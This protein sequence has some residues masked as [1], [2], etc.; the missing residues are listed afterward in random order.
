[1]TPLF[2]LLDLL[3][4]RALA[5]A[6]PAV[7]QSSLLVL[8]LLLTER[9]LRHKLRPAVR[10]ALWL[11]V[12]IKLLLPPS[13][14]LPT[15]IGYW[16]P[17][18]A[19]ASPQ[20][21]PAAAVDRESP[22]SL[23][24][25][26]PTD[27]P[28]TPSTPRPAASNPGP[29]Q[30]PGRSGFLLLGWLAGAAGLLAWIAA[31]THALKRL[32][33]QATP[34]P[35]DVVRLGETV[36]QQLRLS[37]PVPIRLTSRGHSPALCGLWRPVVLIPRA[38]LERLQPDQLRA[39]LLHE[40][41]HARRGDLWINTLQTLLQIVW[42]WHPFVWVANARLRAARE[43][44]VDDTVAYELGPESDA[45]PGVLLEV[46]RTA[47]NRPGLSVGLIG[48][49][50]SRSGL[51]HRIERLLDRR[52]PVPPRLG[53]AALVAIASAALIVLPMARGTTPRTLAPSEAS[54]PAIAR[55][56]DRPAR[57]DARL[58]ELR[59]Q[60]QKA[61]SR[62]AVLRSR[63]K[64]AW[65][66]VAEQRT[67]IEDLQIELSR[68]GD[69]GA[70]RFFRSAGDHAVLYRQ[71]LVRRFGVD[72]NEVKAQTDRVNRL[73]TLQAESQLRMVETGQSPTAEPEPGMIVPRPS[74]PW[75]R[76]DEWW[77]LP[78]TGT[79]S[80][81]GLGPHDTVFVL[82]NPPEQLQRTLGFDGPQLI[83][84]LEEQ[85]G[86]QLG[87]DPTAW[88]EAFAEGLQ[89]AGFDPQ[90]PNTFYIKFH[91]G[92]AMI[93][94][95]PEETASVE[96]WLARVAPLAPRILIEAQAYLLP[97]DRA[98]IAEFGPALG[99]PAKDTDPA[100]TNAF[101]A[102]QWSA[103]VAELKKHPDIQVISRP[104]IITISRQGAEVSDHPTPPST[105][106]AL[107]FSVVRAE[108]E[109]S[110]GIAK[111]PE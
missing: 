5:F 53:P 21:P 7:V 4:H 75:P 41:A 24:Y 20:A 88:I 93:R 111:P 94:G 1:M 13:L 73:T 26:T 35:E 30:V 43:E 58:A 72:S 102:K 85:S 37:R 6:R 57:D 92:L 47:L 8:T 25:F 107:S 98:R 17:R 81:F 62:L 105:N 103:W 60:L 100:T 82:P 70:V 42:W 11:L 29:I 56:P 2:E 89:T 45:Y 44:T 50:E 9:I 39:V 99:L 10:Y 71:A 33:R 69:P 31:R 110:E 79:E 65:P 48:I 101:S 23:R 49:L 76:F 40:L 15:G 14:A 86:R 80:S 64:A 55:T 87:E 109:E 77:N 74:Q 3:S 46:A 52:A 78:L 95:K 61:E 83:A 59:A 90:P 34:A 28:A 19:M 38:L 84:V 36:R 63:Y 51:R 68:L 97:A 12:P 96:R 27:P 106:A 66:E 91:R 104:R 18:P 108:P 67:H 32:T 54:A 22:N 16:L